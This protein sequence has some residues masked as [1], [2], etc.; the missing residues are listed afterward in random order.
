MSK[1]IGGSRGSGS[2]GCCKRGGISV[3]TQGELIQPSSCSRGEGGVEG[4]GRLEIMME[5]DEEKDEPLSLI[6]T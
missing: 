3:W 5:E 1:G 4:G 2:K 6:A